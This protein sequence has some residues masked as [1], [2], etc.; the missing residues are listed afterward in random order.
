MCV[1]FGRNNEISFVYVAVGGRGRKK[2]WDNGKCYVNRLG[3]W[4]SE[5]CWLTDSEG[6]TI[7]L[8]RVHNNEQIMT[9]IVLL[10]AAIGL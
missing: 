10:N 1:E 8:Q 5:A 3:R 7:F 6:A 4:R 9:N 2:C